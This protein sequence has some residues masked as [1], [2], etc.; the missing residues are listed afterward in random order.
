LNPQSS[1]AVDFETTY[2]KGKRD[3]STLGTAQYLRHQETK[4]YL[5]S[6]YGVLPEGEAV[7]YSGPVEQAPWHRI[8]GHHWVS[9]NAAFDAQVFIECI[10]R[11][12]AP[13]DV[14]PSAWDCTADLAAFLGSGRSLAA[15]CEFLL[16]V[17]VDKTV[18]DEMNNKTWETMTPE[19]R[20]AAIDYALNDAKRC[21]ELWQGY[22]AQWP[23]QEVAISRHTA[24]MVIRGIHVD[25]AYVEQSISTLKKAIFEVEG[26]IPWLDEKDAKGKFYTVGSKKAMAKACVAAGIPPPTSTADKN[27]LFDRWCAQ[28]AD[29]A[30][31]VAAVKEHRS[32][33]RT[34]DVLEKIRDRTLAD[35]RMPYGL[36]Y[37][38][39]HC[40]PGDHEVLTPSGWVRLD[41]WSGGPIAQRSVTGELVF[42]DAVANRF[43]GVQEDLLSV[44]TGH[45]RFSVTE[46]HWVATISKTGACVK[47]QAGELYGKRFILPV[48]AKRQGGVSFDA[49]RLRLIVAVQADGHYISDHRAIRFRFK[50]A[51]KI[52]RIRTLLDNAGVA[53]DE[54]RYPCEP[55]VAVF[56]VRGYPSWLE[57]AKSLPSELLGANQETLDVFFDELVH[58]D[59]TRS[60]P[61]SQC[62]VS[63][64]KANAELVQ[65]LAHLSG[66]AANL[67]ERPR[68]QDGWSTSYLV[69]LR[70][71]TETRVDKVDWSRRP[72]EGDVYCPTTRTG[73][74]LARHD[75]TIFFTGNTGRWSGDSGLNL[76]NLTTKKIAG[77][78]LRGC[79]VPAPGKKFIVADLKQIEA[80]VSLW[81]AEDWAQLELLRNGM[82]VYEA[83]ARQTMGYKDPMP[84]SEWVKLPERTDAEKNVRQIAKARV[85]GLGFGMGHVR[86]IEYAKAQ[87]GLELTVQQAKAIVN[88][89]RNANRGIVRFWDKLDTA[90]RRHA[91]GPDK[92]AP[93]V[94][95]LPSWRQL[96]Y[97]DV[98]ASDGL[99]ARDEIGGRMSHWFGGKLA[100]NVVQATARD[101]LV[102][103]ILRIESVFPGSVV[104]HVHDEVVC[105]VD[106]SVDPAEIEALMSVTPDWVEGL[107]VGSSVEEA[108]R[109]FK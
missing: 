93:F 42:S 18:R 43:S 19:F 80:R 8:N 45:A 32:I 85:L 95:E 3:I 14:A 40:L 10:R 74:F 36:K 77:V 35:G 97:Y 44:Q 92:A 30:P 94:I 2:S 75:G 41:Q 69:F 105:E 68:G 106:L 39:A 73:V 83:H 98:N 38:G 33:N 57:G 31:F 76:H 67:V 88:G 46:G 48:S 99:Q 47:R 78:D 50:R 100:E 101:V 27:E 5:V 70:N 59:G 51:R 4:I 79:I 1:F 25:S 103:A 23:A 11:G 15:A 107:P 56:H 96:E 82:D 24:D 53:W 20:Q 16:G 63:T 71:E 89:F 21:W 104:L 65:T 7:A 29:Q 90:M 91:A 49:D 61:S 12:Q 84:L 17:T 109:Y 86:L 22:G 58:W 60:G 52:E 28:F 34:I 13:E 6:I 62:Y 37:F 64:V 54:T 55:G 87:L 108:E 81:F 9:H 72:A 102:E 66:R 26:R